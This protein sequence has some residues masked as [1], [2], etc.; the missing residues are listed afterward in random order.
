MPPQRE[1]WWGVG[2]GSSHLETRGN[3]GRGGRTSQILCY[4]SLG[5]AG[6][7][8]QGHI[9]NQP[10]PPVLA[11]VTGQGGDTGGDGGSPATGQHSITGSEGSTVKPSDPIVIDSTLSLVSAGADATGRIALRFTSGAAG[12]L[13]LPPPPPPREGM[14][15]LP[16]ELARAPPTSIAAMGSSGVPGSLSGA[17]EPECWCSAGGRWQGAFSPGTAP[18]GVGAGERGGGGRGP[19]TASSATDVSGVAHRTLGSGRPLT[20][21]R[22]GARGGALTPRTVRPR[23]RASR[24]SKALSGGGVSCVRSCCLE[25]ATGGGGG[26]DGRCADS[27]G[28]RRAAAADGRRVGQGWSSCVI[29][30]LH[31]VETVAHTGSSKLRPWV[32]EVANRSRCSASGSEAH[33]PSRWKG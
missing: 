15:Y 11:Y 3:R 7:A 10:Q 19:A 33:P 13:A 1:R 8:S 16:E 9:F 21:P 32:A 24:R 2:G 28:C 30:S 27:Q 23:R 12:G 29:K 31:D 6:G 25:R 5:F 17:G 22:G 4:A 20:L 18:G 26:R 14:G